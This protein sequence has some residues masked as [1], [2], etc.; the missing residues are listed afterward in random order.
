MTKRLTLILTLFL[1]S[2]AFSYSI[3]YTFSEIQFSK[4]I[5]E[6]KVNTFKNYLMLYLSNR[7]IIYCE[8]NSDVDYLIALKLE[9]NPLNAIYLIKV[10]IRGYVDKTKI[11][12]DTVYTT[13]VW[14]M[15]G[16]EIS[17]RNSAKRIEKLIRGK[18]LPVYR[19]NFDYKKYYGRMEKGNNYISE[20]EFQNLISIGIF[21]NEGINSQFHYGISIKLLEYSRIWF[22]AP[23]PIGIGAGISVLDIHSTN[24]GGILPLTIYIPLYI[25][26]DDYEFNRK[27]L[28]LTFEWCGLLPGYSY[29]DISLKYYFNNLG[30]SIGWVYYPRFEDKNFLREENSKF[31]GGIFFFIGNYKMQFAPHD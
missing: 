3:T 10:I 25:F 2:Y 13:D 21:Y 8:E 6:E 20:M 14:G 18:K 30:I 27:N 12:E 1:L 22:L 31:Y 9:L 16:F 29:F 7:N 23:L 24:A 11:F 4:E 28:F 17:A 15:S 5:Q 19:E 26:P